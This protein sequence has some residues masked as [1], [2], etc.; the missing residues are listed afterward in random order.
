MARKLDYQDVLI[1]PRESTINSRNDVTTEREFSF[2][3]KTL[4]KGTPIIAANMDGV[5]TT[6]MAVQLAKAGMMTALTKFHDADSVEGMRPYNGHTW[7]TTGVG[8]EDF[9]RLLGAAD[10]MS[11]V[12]IC[13]DIANG[14]IPSVRDR[15]KEIRKEFPEAVIMAGNV[16]TPEGCRLLAEAGADIIK[17]GIGPGSVC[18]TR[19]MTG[20]GYPQFS[21]VLECAEWA[22]QNN[23]KQ[24]AAYGKYG[25]KVYICADGGT[26]NPGD[27]V[28]AYVAGADFVMI[29]GMF[30]GHIE[31]GATVD[32]F[33]TKFFGMASKEAIHAHF[34]D[35]ES[36]MAEGKSVDVPFRGNVTVTANRML[37]GIRSAM[38]Y[39]NA[40][41]LTDLK[42]VEWIE[43]NHQYNTVFGSSA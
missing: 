28:K 43:V 37:A 1:V 22:K 5:G 15:I 32:D 16:V 36:F 40:H 12:F 9:G 30:A 21:A 23:E 25:H 10:Q 7:L 20:V 4:F 31:G 35:K 24:W 34:Q 3:G 8:D 2:R 18:T 33:K 42:S 29:G 39:V 11:A 14:Y 13:V 27:I 19:L 26:Q 41:E 6:S 38:T 17:I